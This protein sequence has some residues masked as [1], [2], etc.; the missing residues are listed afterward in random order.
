[1]KLAEVLQAFRKA[2]NYSIREFAKRMDRSEGYVSKVEKNTEQEITIASLRRFASAFN[3][4][5]STILKIQELSE[6]G[7]WSFVKT[8]HEISKLYVE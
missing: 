5:A 7:N 3:V 1:M 8:M 6:E 4:P 2:N